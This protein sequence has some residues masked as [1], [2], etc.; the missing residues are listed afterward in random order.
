MRTNIFST[1]QEQPR[2]NK[3]LLYWHNK[4]Y[5]LAK[6]GTPFICTLWDPINLSFNSRQ[7]HP[8]LVPLRTPHSFRPHWTPPG[9]SYIGKASAYHTVRRNTCREEGSGG[10]Y[11]CAN[12]SFFL[13]VRLKIW[14][15]NSSF[16][17]LVWYCD[18]DRV[19]YSKNMI[20]CQVTNGRDANK[21]LF[22]VPLISEFGEKDPKHNLKNSCS[23]TKF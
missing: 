18:F 19:C 13:Q 17:S 2:Q 14:N 8:F 4:P 11:S 6:K 21:S 7:G 22:L 5:E 16:N 15:R 3:N 10:D 9:V 1:G 12:T 23:A 20:I